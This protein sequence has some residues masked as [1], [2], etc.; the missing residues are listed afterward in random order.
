MSPLKACTKNRLSQRRAEIDCNRFLNL[1][2]TLTQKLHSHHGPI[3]DPLNKVSGSRADSHLERSIPTEGKVSE[4][5][6]VKSSSLGSKVGPV[7]FLVLRCRTW[8]WLSR[9][10]RRPLR[11]GVG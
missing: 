1:I 3:L 9:S 5:F 4:V 2:M 6:K 10:Y 11:P 7:V 8:S